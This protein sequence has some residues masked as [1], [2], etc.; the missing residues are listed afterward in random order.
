MSL[1]VA[2]GLHAVFRGTRRINLFSSFNEACCVTQTLLCK[3]DTS[4]YV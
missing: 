3:H 4:V 1:M 2:Y